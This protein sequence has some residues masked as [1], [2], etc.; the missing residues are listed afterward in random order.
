MP[1]HKRVRLLVLPT[2]VGLS[3]LLGNSPIID[4][5]GMTVGHLYFY[6][7]DVLPEIARIRKWR[8]RHFLPTPRALKSLCTT[9]RNNEP[10]AVGDGNEPA[11]VDGDVADGAGANFDEAE[12]RRRAGLPPLDEAGGDNEVGNE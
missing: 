4:L 5:M 7:E 10:E 1:Y 3:L 6:L 11:R 9:P 12:E 8:L 2:C